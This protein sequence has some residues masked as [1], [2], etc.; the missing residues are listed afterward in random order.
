MR[1]TKISTEYHLVPHSKNTPI[2][3]TPGLAAGC[4]IAA[5]AALYASRIAASE[6]ERIY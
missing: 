5:C 1:A 6:R 2:I 3:R 4:S